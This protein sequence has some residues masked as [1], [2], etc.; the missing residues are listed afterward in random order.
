MQPEFRNEKRGLKP[1]K[2]KIKILYNKIKI[3]INFIVI[4]IVVWNN[5]EG[6]RFNTY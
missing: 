6:G 2:I 1:K 5:C 3:I 4:A